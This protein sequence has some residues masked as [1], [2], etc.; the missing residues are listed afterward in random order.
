MQSL[1][2]LSTTEAEY[3]ALSAALREVIGLMNLLEELQN[4][5]FHIPFLKPTVKCKTFEDNA[6]CIQ[7][8]TQP[9]MRPRTR[10]LAARLHHFRQKV[11]DGKIEIVYCPSKENIADIF[12]K[13]LEKPA[14][15]YLRTK[16]MGWPPRPAR[17]CKNID[18]AKSR[19]TKGVRIKDG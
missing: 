2:A 4:R 18:L 6:S 17:E 7:V 3:I 16:L 14:F 8:A 1:V 10:H 15:E 11:L 9:K 12:T 19:K 5:G 13:A